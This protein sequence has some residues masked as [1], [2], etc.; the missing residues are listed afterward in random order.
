MLRTPTR[1]AVGAASL[2]V[3]AASVLAVAASAQS[4]SR[5]D[6]RGRP[7]HV[8]KEC[9]DHGVRHRSVSSAVRVESVT[10]REDRRCHVLH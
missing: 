9:S 10:T 6:H 3:V 8:F 7:L 2:L 1:I 5:A 4:G